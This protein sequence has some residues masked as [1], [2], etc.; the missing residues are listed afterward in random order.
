MTALSRAVTSATPAAI[1]EGLRGRHN[2]RILRRTQRALSRPLARVAGVEVENG[3]A[4]E[5]FFLLPGGEAPGGGL[6]WSAPRG[7]VFEVHGHSFVLAMRTAAD[8]ER[9]WLRRTDLLCCS[10]TG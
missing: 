6:V 5:Q 4:G 2:D 3:D 9:C 8:R 7:A 10:A 1:R